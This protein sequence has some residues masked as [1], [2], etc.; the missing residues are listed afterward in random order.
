MAGL[1]HPLGYKKYF[2]NH[3]GRLELDSEIDMYDTISAEIFGIQGIPIDYYPSIVNE[4]ADRIFGEDANKKYIRKHQLTAI[5]KDGTVEETLL[6]NGFGQ[7]NVVEFGMYIHINTFK[8]LFGENQDP[9]PSD[10]FTFPHNTNLR[11][12]VSHVGFTTLGMEGNV[13][14]HRTS[15]EL[16]CREA[17]VS[18]ADEGVSEQYGVIQPYVV[19]QNK[20]G[21]T[22]QIVDD[23]YQLKDLNVAQCNVGQTVWVLLENIPCDAILPDGRI[24]D[25][26]IVPKPRIDAHKGDN[27]AIQEAADGQNNPDY[28]EDNRS[29]VIV[30]RDRSYWGEW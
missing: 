24:A 6:I 29:P 20:V 13:F 8:L 27:A 5:L 11:F 17:E 30:P 26:Y 9:K 23:S 16:I 19:K 12:E 22:I 25:K 7:L 1:D 10:Q 2:P 3:T 21:C 4:N 18:A 14:G 15:Y 28:N